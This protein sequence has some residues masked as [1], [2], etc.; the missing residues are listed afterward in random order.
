VAWWLATPYQYGGNDWY[1]LVAQEA[2]TLKST[3]AGTKWQSLTNPGGAASFSFGGTA[4]NYW[5]TSNPALNFTGDLTFAGWIN[6]TAVT[7]GSQN[8]VSAFQGTTPFPGWGIRYSGTGNKRIEYWDGGTWRGGTTGVIA[9]TATWYHIAVTVS[10]TSVAFYVNGAAQ[11]TSTSSARGSFAGPY[12]V[13][14]NPGGGANNLNG[15][16]NDFSAWTRT[17]SSSEI[18][19]LYWVSQEGYPDV[20]NFQSPDAIDVLLTPASTGSF[21]LSPWVCRRRFEP[22]YYE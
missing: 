5:K 9:S 22:A 4:N 1:D 14:S 10:G 19:R 15:A 3:V 8:L 21:P 7:A 6:L 16:F 20:L 2:L 18:A 13:G 12:Y 11:G 17:L